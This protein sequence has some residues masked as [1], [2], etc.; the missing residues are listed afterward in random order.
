[1]TTTPD[2]AAAIIA[3]AAAAAPLLRESAD[4]DRAG[5]LDAAADALDDARD[6]L[7]P[8]AHEESRLPTPRLQ[9]EVART[10]GQLRLLAEVVREGSWREAIIDHAVPERAQPEL[11]RMLIPVGVVANYSASNFPFAFSV[12]GGDTASALAAGCPV[13]VKAHSGHP[14]LSERTAEVLSAALVAAGAPEGVVGLVHGREMGRELIVHPSIA[15]GSFTGSV[16]GGRALFDLA[17]GR[18]DPIPFYGELGS[19]NPVVITAT[20]LSQDAAGLAA[21]LAASFTLGV[22]QFCTNPGLIFVPAGLGFAEQVAAAASGTA[23]AEM[24]T[25]GIASAYRDGWDRLAAVADVRVVTAVRGSDRAAGPGVAVTT[26]AAFAANPV[27][28]EE[29]FGPATLIVEYADAADLH[30][31]L[32]G[33]SGSLTATVH[34]GTGEEIGE[35]VSVLS[36]RAGRVLF[37]GWPTGV[38]VTWSQHHGGPWPATTSLHTSVG[39]TSLR[40]FLRPIVFQDAPPAV[41]PPALRD[42]NPLGIPRR[43][44]G[45]LTLD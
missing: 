35:L 36:T 20:A 11:R 40:R 38:A 17:A 44:N 12:A 10:T 15:A 4:L 9:G 28:A 41:L 42:E 27:L 33:L 19:V 22:G 7:V 37:G 14:L 13:V 26:L 45:I 24:L 34:A 23:E 16:G 25:P 39:A 43:V 8:I 2:E 6:E 5:W 18:P 31:V 1:M 21:G 30:T 3:R 29:V 32:G